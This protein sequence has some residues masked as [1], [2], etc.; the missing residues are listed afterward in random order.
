MLDL[1]LQGAQCHDSI[2]GQ[3]IRSLMPCSEEKKKERERAAKAI[4]NIK[5]KIPESREPFR[6]NLRMHSVWET[7]VILGHKPVAE[8]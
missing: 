1:P 5:G 8:I 2:P 3:E 7:S 4:R 6:S